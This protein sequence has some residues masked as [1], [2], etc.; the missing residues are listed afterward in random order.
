MNALL[1]IA[2]KIAKLVRL[3]GSDRDGEVLAAVQAIKRALRT[4]HLDLHTLADS[5]ESA[6]AKT[7]S[8][9]DARII[10][11]EGVAEGRRQAQ[12]D[13]P[14]NFNDVE[15]GQSWHA[16][17][18]ACRDEGCWLNERERGFVESMNRRTVNGGEPSPSKLTGCAKYLRDDHEQQTTNLLCRSCSSAGCAAAVNTGE[19]MGGVAVGVAPRQERSREMDKAT[20]HGARSEV[21]CQV[22]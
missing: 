8:E 7:F 9:E 21:Q 22:E 6:S 16:I 18:C 11:A 19:E 13:Q 2:D 12:Q 10:F 15:T 5:I 14:L 1:P 4:E 3:L 20:T 17:A